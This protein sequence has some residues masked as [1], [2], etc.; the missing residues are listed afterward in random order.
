MKNVFTT[1]SALA[2]LATATQAQ[3]FDRSQVQFWVGSGPDSTVLVIDF[4]DGTDDQSYAWGFLHDGTATAEDMLNAI[5]AA[6]VNLSVEITSGFLN[7]VT[8]G[9]HAG[10]GGDPDWWSTWSGPSF[11]GMAMNMGI[12]EVLSNG[13]WFGCSYTDFDPAL[14]LTTPIAAID[15]LAFTFDDVTFWVGS[16]PDSTVLVV[17]FQDGSGNSSFAW[18]YLHDEGATAEMMLNAVVAADPSLE[19]VITGG[20]LSDLT[21]MTYAGIGGDPDWWSTWNATNMGDWSMNLGLGTVL[22]NGD[23]FGCSYTD[24]NPALRPGTPV[25]APFVTHVGR[26]EEARVQA[27]PQPATN[28]LHLAGLTGTMPLEVFNMAGERIHAGMVT[29]P[30]AVLDVTAWPAGVYVLRAGQLSRLIAVH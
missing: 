29:G 18:G 28:V 8:Y 3:T 27:W 16:G 14:E 15:P 24:F 11:A 5:D 19:A 21:Y 30:E 25:A 4:Q 2:L 1:L 13:S 7:S 26:I 12:S 6:D 10:I 9:G 22:G 20:F 17:D 23:F